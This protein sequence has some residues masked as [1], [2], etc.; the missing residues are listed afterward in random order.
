MD[1]PAD[2]ELWGYTLAELRSMRDFA[3]TKGWPQGTYVTLAT[4]YHKRIHPGQDCLVKLDCAIWN[5]TVEVLSFAEDYGRDA[6]FK[7]K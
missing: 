1:L 2:F 6:G 3:I 4:D 7:L 5:A